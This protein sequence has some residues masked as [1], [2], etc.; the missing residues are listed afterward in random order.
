MLSNFYESS[1]HRKSISL[2]LFF[3]FFFPTWGYMYETFHFILS[4]SI[5][6]H[7]PLLFKIFRKKKNIAE[8]LSFR[9]GSFFLLYIFFNR[10]VA[11]YVPWIWRGFSSGLFP[12]K[13]RRVMLRCLVP[14]M[15]KMIGSV[16]ASFERED[17]W[18][19][20][21]YVPLWWMISFS[22]SVKFQEKTLK[23]K[24]VCFVH[25]FLRKIFVCYYETVEINWRPEAQ[26]QLL[27]EICFSTSFP[28]GLCLLL[29]HSVMADSLW[30]LGLQHSRIPCPP[31]PRAWSN[32]RLLSL[33]CPM[34]QGSGAWT[35]SAW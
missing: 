24:E 17:W 20:L 23:G 31:S 26:W 14:Q 8:K 35:T 2:S 21:S 30:P 7:F 13:L 27:I 33:W 3:F 16:T 4:G 34:S 9:C 22:Q 1:S 28:N 19:N 29:S 11:L 18:K 25:V 6:S 12:V 15:R 32:S 10:W 5:P